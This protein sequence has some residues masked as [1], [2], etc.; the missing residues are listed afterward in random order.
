MDR[1]LHAERLHGKS[2]RTHRRKIDTL[3]DGAMIEFRGEAFAVRGKRLLRWTPSGYSGAQ[4]RPRGIEVDTLTPPAIIVVLAEAALAQAQ[5]SCRAAQRE[6][7]LQFKIV[8]SV[9]AWGRLGGA[10][11]LRSC[12]AASGVSKTARFTAARSAPW[13][14]RPARGGP[15]RSKRSPP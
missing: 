3:P 10:L 14:A 13:L 9:F 5:R 12:C 11:R 15:R 6:A 2:K 1:A 7:M 8:K 4:P